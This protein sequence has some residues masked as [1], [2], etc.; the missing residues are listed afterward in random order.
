MI[1]RTITQVPTVC[2][3]CGVGCGM[4]LQVEDGGITK[5]HR[6]NALLSAKRGKSF[7][8]LLTGTHHQRMDQVAML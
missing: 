1:D 5:V 4:V 7:S 6:Y 3:Y 8:A 2:P